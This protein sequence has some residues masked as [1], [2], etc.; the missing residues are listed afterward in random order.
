MGYDRTLCI[1]D[2]DHSGASGSQ[3]VTKK[4]AAG[5]AMLKRSWPPE[6]EPVRA[7]AQRLAR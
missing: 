4:K 1:W 7:R 3:K 6:K 2:T 5:E